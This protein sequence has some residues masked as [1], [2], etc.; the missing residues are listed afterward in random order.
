MSFQPVLPLA[1]LPQGAKRRVVIGGR[2]LCLYHLSD[3]I[4][5]TENICS[6]AQASLAEGYLVDDWMIECP[7]HGSRFNIRTGGVQS[8]PA[9]VSLRTFPVKIEEGTIYVDVP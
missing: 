7:R 1:E 5:A 8:L 2:E 6:H 4:F 9:T 3:G